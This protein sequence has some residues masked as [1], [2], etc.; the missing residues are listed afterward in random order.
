MPYSVK[1]L[2]ITG[3]SGAG[4]STLAQL[5]SKYILGAGFPCIVL[6]G[7]E[8]RATTSID[9]GFSRADRK[10]H[11]LRTARLARTHN[12]QRKFVIASLISPYAEDREQARHIISEERFVEVYVSTPLNVCMTRDA[13][14]LYKRAI[15]GTIT[16]FTGITSPYQPPTHPDFVVDLSDRLDNLA[17]KNF[18]FSV[19]EQ[20]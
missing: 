16:E 11:L 17:I 1:T 8:L 5:I 18:A 15:E 6:D 13:K 19:I 4:K 2:W 14:G 12:D 20:P 3:L 9:L 7:D 10:E